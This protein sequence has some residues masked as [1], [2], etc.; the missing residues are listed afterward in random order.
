MSDVYFLD[1]ETYSEKPIK[2]GSFRYAMDKSTEVLCLAYSLNQEEPKLWYPGL[3]LP[4]K[5]IN[6]IKK[7]KAIRSFNVSFEYAIFNY[8]GQKYG[9][10]KLAVNQLLCTMTDAL[11]LALPGSLDACGKALNL[12]IVKDKR[13]K[14]LIQRLCKPRKATKNK[15]YT[16]IET[17]IEPEMFRELYDYCLQDV[18]SEIEIYKT[19]PRHVK[20]T[21]LEIFHQTLEINERGLPIDMPLVG[22]IQKQRKEY[23]ILLNKEIEEITDG[24]LISTMS[25]P[26]SLA[27]LLENGVPLDGYTKKDIK[28]ALTR[29]DLSKGAGRFLEIRSELSRTP[30]KKYQFLEEAICPDSTVKNNLIFHKATTGRFAGVGFQIQNLPRDVSDTPEIL[31]KRFLENDYLG[32][33]NI[34]NEGIKLIRSVI[35]APDNQKLIV[36]DFSS[37]ENRVIAWL[38]G[39][40][41]TLEDFRN[42]IDQYKKAAT[43]IYGCSLEEVQKEQRQLGKIAILSCGFGGGAGTFKHVCSESWG[44]QL[45][46]DEAKAIVDSYRKLYSLIVKM[47]YAMYDKAMRAIATGEVTKYNHI[48]FRLM[49]DFLYMRLPSGRLLAYYKPELRKVMT[50]W[51]QEKLAFTHMGT[52]TYTRKWERLSVTP[53]RLTENATQAVARDF[54]TEA[55]VRVKNMGYKTVAT[56]HDEI[57]TQV[58]IDFSNIENL[59]K[60]ISVNPSWALDCPIEAAG[61]EAKRYKK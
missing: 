10:P 48:Q 57:I 29:P 4:E 58:P 7:G 55:M 12:D 25:R 32:K 47:W 45:S 9:F 50:P 44:I 2:F 13:G 24:R 1:F 41:S 18:R 23:E 34:Y 26:K 61:F 40:E 54:L 33:R 14:L 37:I 31:I 43:E 52:N 38:A 22:A 16:R 36:S 3:P 46:D 21:E 17:H 56:V 28:D 39:D 60:I 27:W 30:I 5:L 8:V 20:G 42:G 53:G 11:A 51:G 6:H 15:P 59:N 35:M 19:L 49:K